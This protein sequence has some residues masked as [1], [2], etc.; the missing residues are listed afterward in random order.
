[1]IYFETLTVLCRLF[2][3]PREISVIILVCIYI[4]PSANAQTANR[5]LA[6]IVS[7]LESKYPNGLIV[8][9]GDFNHCNLKKVLPKFFQQVSCPTREDKTID[10]CY[11][12]I[13]G[14]YRSF[15]R[16]PLGRSDHNVVQ[17]IPA[18]KQRLKQRKPNIR[19]VRKLSTG[20]IKTLKAG[21]DCT[22]WDD[23]RACFTD[24]DEYTDLVTS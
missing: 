13:K 7:G 18:Y 24:L 11:C 2:Y 20:A 14:A 1:M 21:F 9:L 12:K 19:S 10:L 5:T 3:S 16:A 23:L 22:A 15:S 8:I 4:P 17:L 6:D